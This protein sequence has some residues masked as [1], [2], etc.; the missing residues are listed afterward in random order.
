MELENKELCKQCGGYC[1]KKSGCDYFVEDFA[2]LSY[3]GL[4]NVLAEGNISI[5]ALL[6]FS[7]LKTGKL[8]FTPILY[9]RA[10]NEGRDVVDLVSIKKSCSLLKEDGCSYDLANRPSGGVNLIPTGDK[11]KC[12]PK[13]DALSAILKWESYQKVLS[14]IVKRYTGVS[15]DEKIRQDVYN[16]FVEFL[17]SELEKVPIEEKYDVL[18]M[19]ESLL[20]IFPKE[21][22]KATNDVKNKKCKKLVK[23]S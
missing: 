15:V 23:Q 19:M 7:K 22:E 12:Y 2:D 6:K 21:V 8:T 18:G 3:K 16:L 10:R 17:N 1:C 9:L 11:Y 5:V 20:I 14:R 13:E 4:L